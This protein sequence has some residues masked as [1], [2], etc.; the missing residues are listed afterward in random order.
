MVGSQPAL[1]EDAVLRLVSTKCYS[2]KKEWLDV[3]FLRGGGVECG[4]EL[5]VGEVECGGGKAHIS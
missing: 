1:Q 5:S 2:Q 3:M 4:M